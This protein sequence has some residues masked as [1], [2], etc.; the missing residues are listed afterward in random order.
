MSLFRPGG[1]NKT[2]L[3]RPVVELQ[4]LSGFDTSRKLMR[5]GAKN[6]LLNDFHVKRPKRHGRWKYHEHQTVQRKRWIRE[7]WTRRWKREVK[8]T[9]DMALWWKFRVNAK[10]SYDIEQ[11]E[12]Y[13]KQREDK[14]L[15]EFMKESKY[16]SWNLNECIEER[17]YISYT[18]TQSEQEYLNSIQPDTFLKN[19]R[20]KFMEKQDHKIQGYEIWKNKYDPEIVQ[21]SQRKRLENNQNIKLKGIDDTNGYDWINYDDHYGDK[22]GLMLMDDDPEYLNKYKLFQQNADDKQLLNDIM[23]QQKQAKTKTM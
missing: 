17:D 11:Y 1:R 10:E 20:Q 14:R 5:W 18:K 23:D 15:K 16:T 8:N 13:V 3:V 19:L 4:S 12:N 7:Y 21:R 22:Q 9:A 2:H 6:A